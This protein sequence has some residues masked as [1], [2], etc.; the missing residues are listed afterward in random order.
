MSSQ[1]LRLI[2]VILIALLVANLAQ[3]ALAV[4][5][6]VKITWFVGLGTGTNP[7]QIDA[8]NKVVENFNKSH[9]DIELVINI[10]PHASAVDTLSTLIA[11]GVDQAPDIVGPVGYDGANGFAGNWLDL[12]PLVE[13]NKY[14]LTQYP[15]TLVEFYR[16]SEG[17]VGLPF[18]T[19][20]AMLYYRPE[21]FDEA[22]LAYPPAKYGEPY[23]D[24]KGEKHPWNMD[25]LRE[26]A[27]QMT[28]D[29]KGNNATSKAFDPQNITQWGYIPQ[30]TDARSLATDWGAGTFVTKDNKAFI[31]D[32]WR[33]AF[34]W[35][36]TGIWKDHFIPNTAQNTSDLLGNDNAFNSGHVAMAVTHLWYT[37][38]LDGTAWNVAAV[39]TTGDKPTVKLHADTFR[40]MKSTKHPQ[41]AFTVL[42]YL[43]GDG[44]LDLLS[45]Y[46]G[47]PAR[48][49]DQKAFFES[50]DK[51][52]TQHVN[53]D[54]VV[55]GL[56]YP[57]IPSHESWLPNYLKSKSRIAAFYSQITSTPDLNID[58][59]IDKLVADLQAIYDEK[60]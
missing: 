17:L 47:L 51:K 42:T 53:W 3:P 35:Y 31:P 22:G 16:T 34:E 59:E 55:E 52:Y 44:A 27:I 40:V 14:D 57:D 29:K 4:K 54:V 60:K 2:G 13:Q 6:K 33:K 9:D 56:K 50:L 11:A 46:G 8:E 48:A 5:E 12:Q 38:C 39:P 43:I 26:L 49:G 58:T 10:V 21:L 7:G 18:G 30:W 15:A 1:R 28:V 45:I 19:F 41:E 32:Y 37:C 23:V 24:S 20:P 36:Y 25:T